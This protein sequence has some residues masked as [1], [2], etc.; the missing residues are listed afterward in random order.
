MKGMMVDKK[1]VVKRGACMRL[2]VITIFLAVGIAVFEAFLAADFMMNQ[3]TEIWGRM[4]AVEQRVEAMN[5]A[6]FWRAEE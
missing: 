6:F 4:D 3:M 5:N 1:R 2:A